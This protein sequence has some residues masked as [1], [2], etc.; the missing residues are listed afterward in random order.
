MSGNAINAKPQRLWSSTRPVVY[1]TN[2]TVL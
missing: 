1:L 2:W